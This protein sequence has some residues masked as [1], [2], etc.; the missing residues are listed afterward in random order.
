LAFKIIASLHNTLLATFIKLLESVSK[1]LLRNRLQ[2]GCHTSLDCRHVCKSCAFHDAL[3]AGNRNKSTVLPLCGARRRQI[4]GVRRVDVFLFPL[5]KSIMKG[6]RFADV[7]A[8]EERVTGFCYRFLK[9]PLL[10]ISRIFMKVTN[11]ML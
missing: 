2:N 3:Q 7:T 5:L 6:A 1:S 9:S 4:R 10:T 11:S 8:I